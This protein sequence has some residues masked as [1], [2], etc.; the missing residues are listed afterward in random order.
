MAKNF[1]MQ[2]HSTCKRWV[3]GETLEIA[4]YCNRYVA[5]SAMVLKDILFFIKKFL[6]GMVKIWNLY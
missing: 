2:A 6:R 1:R 4:V 5:E 3:K